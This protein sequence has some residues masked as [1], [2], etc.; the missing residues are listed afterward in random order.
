[1]L[2]GTVLCL[3]DS[4]TFGAR[5]VMG[6][7]E[8]LAPMLS[9]KDIEWACLQHGISGQTTREILD[10]TPSAV[11]SLN[12]LTGPKW[13]VVLAGT[14]DSKGGGLSMKTWE[15]LYRQIL[16]WPRRFNIPM[17]LCTFPTV[18]PHKMP[19]YT[20]QSVRWLKRASERVRAIASELDCGPSPV[21]LVELEDMT[22]DLLCDGVHM[23]AEGYYEIAD[24][25]AE[26]LTEEKDVT[27]PIPKAATEF[28]TGS[29]STKL[30][31]SK[32]TKVASITEPDKP[33]KK[34]KAK[35]TPRRKLV[36]P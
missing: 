17:A 22:T 29:K 30:G 5:A 25:V 31:S 4:L 12:S 23:T 20:A 28:F 11:R 2:Y 33:K 8:H 10:R 6:Y 1:M 35:R 3:G 13:V 34:A 32:R 19:A 14:N 7:P 21:R 18:Q 27:L 26:V 9:T 36:V 15:S 16:H 24:R